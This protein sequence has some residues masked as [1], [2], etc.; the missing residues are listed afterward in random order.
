MINRY[1]TTLE[2][3]REIERDCKARQLNSAW[4]FLG[5][6]LVLEIT[7]ISQYVLVP[8]MGFSMI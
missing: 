4:E 6:H 3:L 1:W 2:T 8:R 7:L 5:F